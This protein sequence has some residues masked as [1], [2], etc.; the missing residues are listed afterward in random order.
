MKKWQVLIITLSVLNAS[1]YGGEDTAEDRS[2]LSGLKFSVGYASRSFSDLRFSTGSYSQDFSTVKLTGEPF[3]VASAAGAIVGSID[4]SYD[5]GFVK[6]DATDSFG[7]VTWNWAYEDSLQVDG[8][9]IRFIDSSGRDVRHDY[10]DSFNQYQWSDDLNGGGPL[11][12]VSY[13]FE[14]WYSFKIAASMELSFFDIYRSKNSST[15]EAH[16]ISNATQTIVQDTFGLGGTVPPEPPHEGTFA[17]PGP[18]INSVPSDRSVAVQDFS[19]ETFNFANHIKESLDFSLVTLSPGISAS[20]IRGNYHFDFGLGVSFNIINWEA[21]FRESLN[22]LNDGKKGQEIN[23]W[24]SVSS[25]NDLLFGAFLHAATGMQISEAL[26]VSVFVRRDWASAL[27]A[28]AGPSN[29]DL[30][31]SGTSGG[32]RATYS[33]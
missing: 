7:E 4:R 31:L 15:F 33:F 1:I 17:D 10:S 30:Q 3:S 23:S 25:G 20:I 8:D 5:D 12:Q 16:R 32:F 9:S 14:D 19:N 2:K 6:I 26:S 21:R 13:N 29:F 28:E 24:E 11:L 18:L 22:V 27:K